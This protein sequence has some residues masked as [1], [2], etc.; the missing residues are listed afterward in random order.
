MSNDGA[1]ALCQPRAERGS[2]ASRSHLLVELEGEVSLLL[3][4][5]DSSSPVVRRP[6]GSLSCAACPLLRM[7]LPARTADLPSAQRGGRPAPLPR[8]LPLHHAVQQVEPD[9]GGRE[10]GGG[11]QQRACRRSAGAQVHDWDEQGH[12][13]WGEGRE[14]RRRARRRQRKQRRLL[15]SDSAVDGHV[16]C[17]LSAPLQP[18]PPPPLLHHATLRTVRTRAHAADSTRIVEAASKKRWRERRWR[19]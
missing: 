9:G 13:C 11:Q 4:V 6:L 5:R 16:A 18:L 7:R 15:R 10:E 14:R 1:S 2:E 3:G 19:S 12:G 17:E 8:S